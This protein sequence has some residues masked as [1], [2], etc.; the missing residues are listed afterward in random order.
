[1]GTRLDIGVADLEQAGFFAS[2]WLMEAH[3][4]QALV[5]TRA[6]CES[7]RSIRST[8]VASAKDFSLL[9][10]KHFKLRKRERASA[11]YERELARKKKTCRCGGQKRGWGWA[12]TVTPT[13]S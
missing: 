13:T 10:N 11:C 8:D 12:N 1:M 6:L 9:L 2:G 7:D 4:V 5:K 3:V